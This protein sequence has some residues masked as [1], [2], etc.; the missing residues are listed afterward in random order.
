[1]LRE[2]KEVSKFDFIVTVFIH[3]YWGTKAF[4]P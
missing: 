2:V 1:M 3:E 4:G